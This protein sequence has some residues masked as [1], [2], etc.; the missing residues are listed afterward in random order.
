[1]S[2]V[3]GVSIE[4]K[5]ISPGGN[6]VVTGKEGGSEFRGDGPQGEVDANANAENKTGTIRNLTPF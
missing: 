5:K 4:V 2:S 1:M 6:A 3:S